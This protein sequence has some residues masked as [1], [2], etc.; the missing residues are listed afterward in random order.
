M[1]ITIPLFRTILSDFLF[2][3]SQG[4]GSKKASGSQQKPLMRILLLSDIVY[5]SQN[6]FIFLLILKKSLKLKLKYLVL[7]ITLQE[8]CKELSCDGPPALTSTYLALK[9]N[10]MNGLV[11]AEHN[12][13]EQ[14]FC[15][16]Y[17]EH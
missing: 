1:K 16:F 4:W 13:D 6:C 8:A 11:G 7:S 15:V 5:I 10:Q 9:K 2:F 12:N 17:Q 3:F 14:Y